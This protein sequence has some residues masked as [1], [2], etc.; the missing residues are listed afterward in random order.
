MPADKIKT[1]CASGTSG[2]TEVYLIPTPTAEFMRQALTIGNKVKSTLESRQA[3][4]ELT[5]HTCNGVARVR[6]SKRI[7]NDDGVLD[8]DT[9]EEQKGDVAVVAEDV[10]VVWDV[11]P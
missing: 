7:I 9:E 1:L 4:Q 8:N 5:T 10:S 6:L 2:T 11:T 3:P